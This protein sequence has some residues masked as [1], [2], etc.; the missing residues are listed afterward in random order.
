[1]RPL[2]TDEPC[3]EVVQVRTVVLGGL[4]TMSLST[5]LWIFV[6]WWIDH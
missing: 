4:I 5:T 6:F 1:M 3:G 2:F